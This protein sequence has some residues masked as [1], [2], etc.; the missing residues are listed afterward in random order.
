[1][2]SRDKLDRYVRIKSPDKEALADL[3]LKAK[4]KDRSLRQ[5]ADDLG[6]NA[7]TLSRIVN[8]KTASSNSDA[9]IADIADHADPNSN[10]TFERLMEA[11]GMILK[12]KVS[13]S[14]WATFGESAKAV[15]VKELV[16]RNYTMQSSSRWEGPVFLGSVLGNC[17][18]DLE[19]HTNALGKEDAVWMFDFFSPGRGGA[20]SN[21]Q[22]LNRIRQ[23][24]LMFAG[25]LCFNEGKVDRLS[26]VISEQATYEKV[27]EYCKGYSTKFGMSIILIDLERCVVV[28]EYVIA[29]KQPERPV[30]YPIEDEEFIG[31]EIS[32]FENAVVFGDEFT[33]ELDADH[34]DD[35]E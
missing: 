26:I 31:T 29:D 4:G 11:H 30:F 9:L 13:G 5:F 27:V 10:V 20:K 7:S 32:N 1:M 16:R 28:D 17:Y 35:D 18:L 14:E 21:E 22:E 8:M 12:D 15:I 19:L 33:F 6:V 23:W 25:M 34:N 24:L 2:N 3:V